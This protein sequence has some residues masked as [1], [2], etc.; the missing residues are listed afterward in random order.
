MENQGRKHLTADTIN[1]VFAIVDYLL[2]PGSRKMPFLISK[3][4]ILQLPEHCNVFRTPITYTHCSTKQAAW[5]LNA[6]SHEEAF[7]PPPPPNNYQAFLLG[8]SEHFQ[9]NLRHVYS[10]INPILKSI[11]IIEES[12][13]AIMHTDSQEKPHCIL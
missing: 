1:N 7:F 9:P 12:Y 10:E 2:N 11:C 3:D 13:N 6:P 8:N 4:H 5:L